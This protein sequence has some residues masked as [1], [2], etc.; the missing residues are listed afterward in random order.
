ML[1]WTAKRKGATYCSPACGRG[2]TYAEYQKARQLARST[3]SSLK[4]A[5]KPKVWENM[6]WFAKAVSSCGQ[7]EV[8]PPQYG[9]GDRHY[10]AYMLGGKWAGASGD[11]AQEAVNDVVSVAKA[12]LKEIMEALA[13]IED[14]T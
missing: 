3:A 9:D 4:G 13:G 10:I 7:V 11:T 12:E 2:C 14:I 8:H 1:S 6:G 5:W